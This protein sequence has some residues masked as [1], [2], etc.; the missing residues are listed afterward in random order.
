[1]GS[2]TAVWGKT[3]GRFCASL[4]RLSAYH[5]RTRGPR[6][7]CTFQLP[8]NS[9]KLSSQ[10]VSSQSG[11]GLKLRDTDRLERA[12]QIAQTFIP[13]YRS[14]CVRG[15]ASKALSPSLQDSQ[16]Q[17]QSAGARYFAAD[18]RPIILFDGVCNFCNGGV[19]FMLDNDPQGKL[20]FAALQ[21][22]AGRALL[23]RAGRAP[24]D[25]SSIVLIEP[26]RSY[27]H[28]EAILRIAQYLPEPFWRA[29]KTGH[30][31]AW[32]C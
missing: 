5:L 31:C 9:T 26:D 28:S 20:R 15:A 16:R 21:S 13:P 10:N 22:D 14:V 7:F 8:R 27:T 11:A 3:T 4:E 24:E 23:Q 17:D 12:P 19:N 2:H 6:S 32:A 29:R 18:K 1:M 30:G 25:I